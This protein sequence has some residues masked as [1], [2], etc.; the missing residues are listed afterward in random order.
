MRHYETSYVIYTP[1]I[2][3]NQRRRRG[4]EGGGSLLTDQQVRRDNL[5][6]RTRKWEG[7]ALGKD[8]RK[9]EQSFKIL[10]FIFR[11]MTSLTKFARIAKY[12]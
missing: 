12:Q 10:R 2:E 1:E 4:F 9:K 5:W 7:Q 11:K 8:R 3:L 6:K